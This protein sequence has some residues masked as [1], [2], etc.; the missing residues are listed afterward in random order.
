M[1]RY[2]YICH[3]C[4]KIVLKR[5]T[6]PMSS[7][8]QY[9]S[10]GNKTEA[11][12]GHPKIPNIDS[13][14]DSIGAE[15]VYYSNGWINNGLIKSTNDEFVI[16]PPLFRFIDN[17]EGFVSKNLYLRNAHM[18]FD[19]NSGI[20]DVFCYE[21]ETKFDTRLDAERAL[22]KYNAW[23]KIAL[24][25]VFH[26]ISIK[27]TP[28]SRY[29]HSIGRFIHI[30]EA[31]LRKVYYCPKCGNIGIVDITTYTKLMNQDI[32][33]TKPV[34]V[35]EVHVR[36]YVKC[37]QCDEYMAEID[38]DISD[39]IEKI[40][41]MGIETVY[42]CQGHFNTSIIINADDGR[43]SKS[44][45]S[46]E[47]PY[48]VFYANKYDNEELIDLV[49][50]LVNDPKYKY[51]SLEFIDEDGNESDE[52]TRVRI[53]GNVEDID[54]EHFRAVQKEFMD[55]LDDFITQYETIDH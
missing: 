11:I 14:L 15:L 2:Y 13:M 44:E 30:R 3:K 33:F 1:P 5:T 39:R 23:I 19:P 31:D 7:D 40:N 52:Y 51:L 42:C 45:Y 21:A 37:I 43:G 54:E 41:T 4:R 20:Y 17:Q 55:F 48:I 46:I 38:F 12:T 9:C 47:C 32:K 8:D 49:Y 53:Y 27:N 26:M 16:D 34:E 35:S 6:D 22:N 10:C 50:D 24:D 36:N 29:T 25:A 18:T 28:K